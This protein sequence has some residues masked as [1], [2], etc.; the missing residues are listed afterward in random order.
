MLQLYLKF[1]LG[2]GYLWK[3]RYCLKFL[4]QLKIRMIFSFLPHLTPIG[5]HDG[6]VKRIDEA[7]WEE[8][9][10]GIVLIPFGV[11]KREVQSVDDMV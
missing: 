11:E 3:D 6:K 2:N 4:D 5:G 1:Y 9:V 7:I 8:I 10:S